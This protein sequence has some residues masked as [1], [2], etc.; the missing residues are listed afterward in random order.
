M[1]RNAV[2]FEGN[3][4]SSMQDCLSAQPIAKSSETP[5]RLKGIETLDD[6]AFSAVCGWFRNAF[7]VEG[8]RNLAH[9]A[10]SSGCPWWR[11]ETPSR[12][13]GIET[14]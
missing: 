4:N 14:R 10:L 12:L 5:S 3:R 9:A 1:F 2:P 7:P 6:F 8:N 13:K 11:S